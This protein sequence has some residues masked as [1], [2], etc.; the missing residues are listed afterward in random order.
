MKPTGLLNKNAYEVCNDYD[1]DQMGERLNKL[2]Q[3][4]SQGTVT[5]DQRIQTMQIGPNATNGGALLEAL[6]MELDLGTHP[7]RS[8]E[9]T[10]DNETSNFRGTK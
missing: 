8:Y 1:Y 7:D 6:L 2:I 3:S 10:P 5:P 9:E 4:P